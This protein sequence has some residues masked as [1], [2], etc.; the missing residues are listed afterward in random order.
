MLTEY[1]VYPEST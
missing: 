1:L